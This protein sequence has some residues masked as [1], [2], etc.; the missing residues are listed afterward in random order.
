MGQIY[1]YLGLSV[2]I[3]VHGLADPQRKQS[4]LADITYGRTTNSA[5]TICATT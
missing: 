1:N 2:G 4:Y 5:S 3:V